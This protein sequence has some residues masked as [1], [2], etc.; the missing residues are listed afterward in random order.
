MV[1]MDDENERLRQRALGKEKKQRKKQT[2]SHPRHLT[3]TEALDALARADFEQKMKNLFKEAVGV[4]R[5]CRKKINAHAKAHLSVD[6]LHYYWREPI[7]KNHVII[8]QAN[9]G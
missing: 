3:A 2:T 6:L 1:L 9:L 4:F 8:G 7:V 5:D